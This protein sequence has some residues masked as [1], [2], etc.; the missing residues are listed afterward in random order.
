MAFNELIGFCF[1]G[2]KSISA[3]GHRTKWAKE[4]RSRV[5]IFTKSNLKKTAKCPP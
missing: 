5:A 2:E 1:K 4:R 3:D